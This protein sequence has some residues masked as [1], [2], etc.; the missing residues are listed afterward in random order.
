M[1]EVV[2]ALNGGV[3]IHDEGPKQ[4][5]PNDGVDKEQNSH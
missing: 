3:G 4:L 5:H 1:S 2:V